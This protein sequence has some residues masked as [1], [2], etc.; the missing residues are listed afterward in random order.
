MLVMCICWYIFS[1]I[2]VSVIE[3]CFESYSKILCIVYLIFY[4]FCN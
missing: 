1:L 3:I 2:C 4:Y